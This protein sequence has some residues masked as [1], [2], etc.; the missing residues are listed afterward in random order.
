MYG[1]KYFHDYCI[2][3]VG[4]PAK[5]SI[6]Q[7]GYTGEPIF[8]D[9][10]EIP[11]TKSLLNNEDDVVGGIY[12]TMANIQ[13]L[14]DETFGMEDLF[15]AN[16]SDFKIIHY[17]DGAV[18][19]IGYLSPE[20]FGED[21][22]EGYRYLD[23]T[24]FD[25]LTKLKDQKFIDET[26]TNYGTV[27]GVYSKSLLFAV[28]ESLKKTGLNL[29]IKTLVD[30]LPVIAPGV[31]VNYHLIEE[32]DGFVY[33]P[34]FNAIDP[35]ILKEGSY[36]SFKYEGVDGSFNSYV[37]AVDRTGADVGVKLEPPIEI[38]EGITIQGYFFAPTVD[39]TKD[40]LAIV[41]H[42][43]R[44]W[45]NP[46]TNV[47]RE[48]KEDKSKKY[49]EFTDGTMSAW[50]VL[51]NLA[52]LSDCKVSQEGGKWVFQSLDLNLVN[53][54]YFEYDYNG[55][56]IERV[57]KMENDFIPCN[58]TQVKYKASGN[59]RYIDKTLKSVSVNYLY[60]YK[61]E[62]DN[63][64]N[65]IDNGTF[66]W[67]FVPPTSTYTP[68][69]W[70]RYQSIPGTQINIFQGPSGMPFGNFISITTPDEFNSGNG[71]QPTK[72]KAIAG[73]KLTFSWWQRV[74]EF[75]TIADPKNYLTLI[76]ELKTETGIY[77][78]VNSEDQEEWTDLNYMSPNPRG[79][80]IKKSDDF[81]WH[82][83]TNYAT[84]HNPTPGGTLSPW[85]RVNIQAEDVPADG[86]VAITFV[87]SSRLMGRTGSS[88]SDMYDYRKFARAYIQDHYDTTE[89]KI[90]YREWA[91]NDP[92]L[93]TFYKGEYPP[94]IQLADVVITKI[95]DTSRGTGRLYEYV[96]SGDYFDSL[97]DIDLLLG[98]ED[99]PDHLS[100][101]KVD[102]VVNDKWVNRDGSLFLGSIGLLTTRSIIRRYL[103]PKFLIDGGVSTF[104]FPLNSV[105]E[106]EDYPNVEW[107]IKSGDISS[108]THLLEGTLCELPK[109]T[110]PI[111]GV[112]YGPNSISGSA[113]S[114]GKSSGTSQSWVNA[115][116]YIRASDAT[117]DKT[118]KRGNESALPIKVRG[119]RNTH[120][121][122]LP[123]ARVLPDDALED[124]KYIH[125]DGNFLY[126]D[127]VKASAGNSDKW[128]GKTYADT[129]DQELK[130]A[131]NVEHNSIKI[132]NISVGTDSGLTVVKKVKLFDDSV[133][134]WTFK[135][136]VLVKTEV[137]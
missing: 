44:V 94:E 62:G 52:L 16:D 43:V 82:Y 42:D 92:Q 58:F 120:F 18:D 51:E 68:P 1:E 96:Q 74:K 15:T 39:Q 79:Q 38:G 75:S 49:Y 28:K 64:V 13:L 26:G 40:F 31:N 86:E 131:S 24:A 106:F 22:I 59:K 4:L 23:I 84:E 109:N 112:D 113:G 47:N 55:V 41:N 25:G 71:L 121:L 5:V 19:W 61:A 33:N 117:L 11:F 134:Q 45:V 85:S 125:T 78:L 77:F 123:T 70:V 3:D 118:L 105:I 122:A 87:G 126:V 10:G 8:V 101:L 114:G 67:P 104:P 83:N 137:V 116:G 99:N 90:K 50:D 66:F 100:V 102:G 60:R 89:K 128:D 9:A 72:I 32:V 98:D 37:S 56:F 132:N 135:S 136:G 115:Q 30:R 124:E 27:D 2:D 97:N 76:I 69:G 63:L 53:D 46:E 14:G 110:L 81:T 17:I 88:G 108:K 7:K 73:D 111:G 6:L 95:A 29:N 57:N 133:E 21:D 93:L 36:L 91:T 48:S 35:E 107:F 103:M 129:F 12:P 119:S 20:S 54:Q 34:G 80:W 127:G 130:K 65:L